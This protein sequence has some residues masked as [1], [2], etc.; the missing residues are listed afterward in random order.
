MQFRVPVKVYD[1]AISMSLLLVDLDK[2]ES[3]QH[4]ICLVRIPTN[5]IALKPSLAI[6]PHF[7]SASLDV[8]SP[9]RKHHQEGQLGIF[10]H[11][12]PAAGKEA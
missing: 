9:V 5:P 12:Y 2:A 6:D 8:L 10:K 3:S 1:S 4:H 11:V 7:P